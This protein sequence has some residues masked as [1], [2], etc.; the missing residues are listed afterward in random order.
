MY[1]DE[2]TRRI[3]GKETAKHVASL[4]RLDIIDIT[5]RG[6]ASCVQYMT[7]TNAE[8]TTKQ[9][10][11]SLVTRVLSMCG[12]SQIALNR[13]F[14]PYMQTLD[15]A[16]IQHSAFVA[17]FQRTNKAGKDR[18]IYTQ[19]LTGRQRVKRKKEATMS[20]AQAQA[21]VQTPSKD[22]NTDETHEV[23]QGEV[24]QGVVST[25]KKRVRNLPTGNRYLKRLK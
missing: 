2:L 5:K 4:V 1:C 18:A 11:F 22:D 16:F 19:A 10:L 3:G 12:H 25:P 9:S 23:A 13:I 7:R 21:Q 6:L 20:Q 17:Q 8:E 14:I 15:V 24:A